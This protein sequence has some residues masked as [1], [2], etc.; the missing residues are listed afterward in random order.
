MDRKYWWMKGDVS[1]VGQV[2]VETHGARAKAW[3][4]LIL[5]EASLSRTGASW[6]KAQCV[7]IHTESVS[8]TGQGRKPGASLYPRKQRMRKPGAYVYTW[9]PLS[10]TGARAKAS[11]LLTH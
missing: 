9:K 11:C 1:E 2:H 5:V 7:L 3:C 8:P 10:L 6:V 4:L